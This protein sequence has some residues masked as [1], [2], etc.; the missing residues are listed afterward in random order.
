[1]VTSVRKMPPRRVTSEVATSGPARDSQ[2]RRRLG[3]STTG[4][5][6]DRTPA[7]NQPQHTTAPRQ[8]TAQ[9]PQEGR[10]GGFSRAVEDRSHWLVWLSLDPRF[11]D[12]RGDPRFAALLQSMGW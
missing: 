3:R 11:A 1:M 5:A 12:L 7:I 2:P 8:A 10:D 6:P 9:G 4:A